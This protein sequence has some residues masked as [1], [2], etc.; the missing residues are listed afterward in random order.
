MLPSRCV[1]QTQ[2]FLRVHPALQES[3]PAEGFLLAC[4]LEPGLLTLHFETRVAHVYAAVCD[5]A[6]AISRRDRSADLRLIPLSQASIKDVALLWLQAFPD[7]HDGNP[8]P[9]LLGQGP[10][11]ANAETS[12]VAVTGNEERPDV[13]GIAISRFSGDLGTFDVLAVRPDWRRRGLGIRL[14]AEATRRKLETGDLR[15]R[16]FCQEST[17]DIIELMQ[18]SS[19]LVRFRDRQWL[20]PLHR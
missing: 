6:R 8:I 9:V 14:I 10:E 13:V 11:A 19:A 16:L 7:A 18:R 12:I 4:G 5:L 2:I 15:I 17:T 1:R 20:R 3:D